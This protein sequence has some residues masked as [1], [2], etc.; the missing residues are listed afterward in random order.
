[1]T[2]TRLVDAAVQTVVLFDDGAVEFRVGSAVGR[3]ERRGRT[4]DATLTAW[5]TLL[6]SLAWRASTIERVTQAPADGEVIITAR[7][8][9]LSYHAAI[10]P[11]RASHARPTP[12]ARKVDPRRTFTPVEQPGI[13]LRAYARRVAEALLGDLERAG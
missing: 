6:A 5:K 2:A 3:L 1:M 9:S 8:S 13:E 7:G 10:T 11:P 4:T 12:P